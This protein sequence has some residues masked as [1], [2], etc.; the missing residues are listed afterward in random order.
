MQSLFL[1]LLVC[2]Q[3]DLP[4]SESITQQ[5]VTFLTASK[6]EVTEQ[7]GKAVILA[8]DLS[9]EV[10]YGVLV[11]IDAPVKWIEIHPVEK[12][13]P[14]IIQTPFRENTFLIRG[15]QGQKFYVSGR[16]TDVPFWFD[17]SIDPRAPQPPPVDPDPKPPVDPV[18]PDAF[19]KIEKISRD[20][21]A[22]LN[23]PITAERLAQAIEVTA[24]QIDAKCSVGQCPTLSAAKASMIQSI[25][26]V[27]SMRETPSGQWLQL[28][29]KPVSDA[30]SAAN[31]SDLKTYVSMMRAAAKGLQ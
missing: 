21:A 2:F 10:S 13:F 30:V 22:R 7:D 14:P 25:E 19:G 23:D 31:P 15:S 1:F 8:E 9:K 29:R 24:K 5:Q 16:G 27:M 20:G 11:K 18:P 12:P 4:G 6:A 17:V 28:W 26:N 3:I